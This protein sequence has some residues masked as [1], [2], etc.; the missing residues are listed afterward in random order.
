MNTLVRVSAGH[1]R[2]N[3][4]TRIR[5]RYVQNWRESTGVSQ[6]LKERN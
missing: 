4:Q 6:D 1:F 2:P 3:G 5:Q